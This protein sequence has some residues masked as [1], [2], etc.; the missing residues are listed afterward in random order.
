MKCDMYTITPLKWQKIYDGYY[1]A[2]SIDSTIKVR[3][4]RWPEKTEWSVEYDRQG[5]GR[6]DFVETAFDAAQTF[7]DNIL[8]SFLTPC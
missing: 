6:F 5:L 7:H 3:R 1:E 4:L 2:R 8:K